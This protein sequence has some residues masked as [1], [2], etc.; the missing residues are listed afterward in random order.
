MQVRVTRP[1]SGRTLGGRRPL[2]GRIHLPWAAIERFMKALLRAE[3]EGRLRD[4]GKRLQF[5]FGRGHFFG[6]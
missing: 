2:D 1:V 6:T 5:R 3:R 4:F